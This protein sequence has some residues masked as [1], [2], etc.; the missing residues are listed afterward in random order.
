MMLPSIA[1]ALALAANGAGAGDGASLVGTWRYEAVPGLATFRQLTFTAEGRLFAD[2]KH[3]IGPY[4][5]EGGKVSAKSSF[6]ETYVYELTSDGRLCVF[7]GPSVMPLAGERD[8]T[9]RAGL[10]YRKVLQSA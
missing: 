5:V 4:R 9:L 8:Q 10:C 2:K 3:L 7:P 1:I 6:G